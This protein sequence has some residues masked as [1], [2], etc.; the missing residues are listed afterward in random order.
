MGAERRISAGMVTVLIGTTLA[1]TV[2]PAAVAAPAGDEVEEARSIALIIV[3][4]AG[5]GGAEDN[6]P[7]VA[8]REVPPSATDPRIDRFGG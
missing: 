6:A 3:Q 8:V 4:A 7:M 5:P 1:E 2:L